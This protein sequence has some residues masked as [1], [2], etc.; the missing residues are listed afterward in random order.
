MFM[1]S[2]ECVILF[3]IVLCGLKELLLIWFNGV[4]ESVLLLKL[5]FKLLCELFIEILVGCRCRIL[6]YVVRFEL[7]K[8]WFLV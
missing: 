2:I 8:L 6:L 3:L 4:L 1:Y 5:K 7:G